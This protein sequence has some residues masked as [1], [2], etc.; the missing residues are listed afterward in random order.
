ML[1]YVRGFTSTRL[2]G[3][4]TSLRLD[5]VRRVFR[6]L[7]DC[8]ELGQDRAA[9]IHRAASGLRDQLDA[10]MTAVGCIDPG[11]EW[12]RSIIP[13]RTMFDVGWPTARDR[14]A[15]LELLRSGRT[16]TYPTVAAIYRQAG[17]VIV[18]SRDQLVTNREWDRSTELHEDR[19]PL[20]QDETLIGQLWHPHWPGAH[21]VFSIN[22]AAGARQFDGRERAFLRLFLG[23]VKALAG[24]ALAIDEAGPF[25]GLTG[26]ARQ[27]LDALLQGDSEKQIAARL[28]VSR[29]TVHDY[30][31]S[32]YHRFKVSS[33]GELLASYYRF[34]RQP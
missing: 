34:N 15:W 26:R 18:R 6:I 29:H 5:D 4:S 33:R 17:T 25:A 14:D 11:W 1:S 8:R 24:T 12:E 10:L 3:K 28:G 16:F 7:G 19:K 9:W 2:M 22:R 21:M 20:G 23:E 30:V 13:G 32:L 27:V 31:K